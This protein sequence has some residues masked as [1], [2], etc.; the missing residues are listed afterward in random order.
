MIFMRFAE[1]LLF[2]DSF[3]LFTFTAYFIKS[4]KINLGIIL[5]VFYNLSSEIYKIKF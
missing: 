2:D 3:I 1:R 5:S 4:D